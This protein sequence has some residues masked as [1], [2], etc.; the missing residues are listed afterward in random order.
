M[1]E[2]SSNRGWRYRGEEWGFGKIDYVGLDSLFGLVNRMNWERMKKKKG[3]S[4]IF[5]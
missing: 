3:K 4:C 1:E 5:P 2:R